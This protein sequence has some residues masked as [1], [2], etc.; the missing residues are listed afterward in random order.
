MLEIVVTGAIL[1]ALLFLVRS[2]K[3]SMLIEDGQRRFVIEHYD[4][5]SAKLY[6]SL[7]RFVIF[8]IIPL[9]AYVKYRSGIS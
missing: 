3:R 9:F 5:S 7:V 1:I 4:V 8:I 6:K 2:F